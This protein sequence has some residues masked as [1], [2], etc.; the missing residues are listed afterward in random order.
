MTKPKIIAVDDQPENL[1]LIVEILK[2]D[3][4]VIASTSAQKTLEL[5]QKEPRPAAILLD[6]SMPEMDGFQVLEQLKD[7]A[8]LSAIPVIFVTGDDDE[9]AF[10][11]GIAM[12]AFD[13][14]LKPVSP[15]LLR[16]R[17]KHCLNP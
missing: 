15:A 4:S 13:F 16:N 12:G 10:E 8:E 11:K 9:A 7:N 14:V 1:S 2:N 3:Y 6:V 17:V 5:A